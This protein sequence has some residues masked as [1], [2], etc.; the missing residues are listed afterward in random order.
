[1]MTATEPRT[2][3]A[4]LAREAP[5]CRWFLRWE[6][7]SY[8]PWLSGYRAYCVN[9]RTGV[10]AKVGP[11]HASKA[12]AAEWR[13]VAYCGG[14]LFPAVC[15]GMSESDFIRLKESLS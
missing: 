8:Y 14:R 13:A 3:A 1:M 6:Q 10:V 15:L 5:H 12:D 11:V 4:K 9:E 7:C 2:P